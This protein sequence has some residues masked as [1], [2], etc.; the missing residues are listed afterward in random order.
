MISQET[1]AVGVTGL[2]FTAH[3]L[4]CCLILTTLVIAGVMITGGTVMIVYAI[5]IAPSAEAL[6]YLKGD[7]TVKVSYESNW[8]IFSRRNNPR[9]GGLIFYPGKHSRF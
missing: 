5:P 6:E 9:N 2:I 3:T 1:K 7:N 8:W 4:I